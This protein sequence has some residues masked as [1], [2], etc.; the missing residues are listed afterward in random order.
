MK[1]RYLV[2]LLFLSRAVEIWSLE[3]V[4]TG[5]VP[6]I[7]IPLVLEVVALMVFMVCLIECIVRIR[8]WLHD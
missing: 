8:K 5:P 6:W 1:N 3:A 4:K 2:V 7:I